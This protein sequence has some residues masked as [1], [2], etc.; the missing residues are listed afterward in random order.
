M[1][2][3]HYP[4]GQYPPAIFQYNFKVIY[5]F[6]SSAIHYPLYPLYKNVCNPLV[7]YSF[8]VWLNLCYKI[9]SYGTNGKHF[10]LHLGEERGR[11]VGEAHRQEAIHNKVTETVET[12]DLLNLLTEIHDT[13]EIATKLENIT[14][15]TLKAKDGN[16]RHQMRRTRIDFR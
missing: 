4:P 11:N 16:G 12:S 10:W 8:S 3:G 7:P 1:V 13:D 15:R 5:C 2:R 9:L 6:R 14:R